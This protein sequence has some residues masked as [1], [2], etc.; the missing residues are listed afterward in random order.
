[1]AVVIAL[2]SVEID[3]LKDLL[4]EVDQVESW[5]LESGFVEE[6]SSFSLVPLVLS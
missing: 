5:G 3:L 6:E 4:E 2:S 1:M